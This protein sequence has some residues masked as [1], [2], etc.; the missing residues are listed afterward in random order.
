MSCS[1]NAQMQADTQ[2]AL[3]TCS[4]MHTH[5]RSTLDA[6]K[7]IKTHAQPSIRA[8]TDTCQAE[9]CPALKMRKCKRIHNWLLIRADTCTHIRSTLDAGKRIKTHAQPSIRADTCTH[10]LSSRGACRHTLSARHRKL[11][12]DKHSALETY[13]LTLSSRDDKHSAHEDT[14]SAL[15]TCQQARHMQTTNTQ[16]MKIRAQ[17]SKPANK[18]GTCRQ[19]TLSI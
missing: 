9:T 2:L 15:E 17:L 14:R 5:I 11:T 4:H 7:R 13:K 16:H 12:E 1:Q 6:D 19:Q 10:T 8:D 3:D 18:R